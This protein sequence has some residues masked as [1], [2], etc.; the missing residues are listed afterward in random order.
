MR[1]SWHKN[2]Y[3]LQQV[4]SQSE[5]TSSKFR[6]ETQNLPPTTSSIDN[7]SGSERGLLQ[8]TRIPAFYI[9][10]NKQSQRK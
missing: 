4:N 8:N 3:W 1:C 7:V 5:P 6:P 2:T 9:K 10:Q